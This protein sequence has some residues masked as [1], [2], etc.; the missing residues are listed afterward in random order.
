[1][2]NG[3]PSSGFLAYLKIIG[4]RYPF[5]AEYKG[6]MVN[7]SPRLVIITSNYSF[8]KLYRFGVNKELVDDVSNDKLY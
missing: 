5:P 8:E 6:G 2:S 1:M 7:I 3:K 4:D